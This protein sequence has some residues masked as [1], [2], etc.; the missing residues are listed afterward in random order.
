MYSGEIWEEALSRQYVKQSVLLGRYTIW[1]LALFSSIKAVRVGT[2]V[3]N[4]VISRK[5][6]ACRSW[7]WDRWLQQDSAQHVEIT[8][9]MQHYDRYTEKM[10][11]ITI[12]YRYSKKKKTSKRTEK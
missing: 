2:L 8:A 10:N 6:F 1:L 12:N 5:F 4:R 11:E 9:A 3:I 7:C